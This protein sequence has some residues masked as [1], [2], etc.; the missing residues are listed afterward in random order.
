MLHLYVAMQ[1]ALESS[2]S[3]ARGDRGQATAEYALVLLG[4][5]AVALVFAA[6][7]MKSGKVAALLDAVMDK[8]LSQL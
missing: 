1:V 4:A 8:I 2:S 5:A 7:A 3:R 6:W